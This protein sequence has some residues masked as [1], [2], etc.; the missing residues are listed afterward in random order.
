MPNDPL[1]PTLKKLEL[2]P[3]SSSNEVATLDR[4]ILSVTI[5]LTAT[6]A[7]VAIK[8][9]HMP[10][11]A[12]SRMTWR[13]PPVRS[14]SS[15]LTWDWGETRVR[16][17]G[18]CRA[19]ARGRVTTALVAAIV[20]VIP[21]LSIVR[22]MRGPRRTN[23]ATLDEEG[24]VDAGI[25]VVA[26][27]GFCNCA[28]TTGSGVSRTMS[29]LSSLSST[30]VD[31]YESVLAASS[32]SKLVVRGLLLR[33]LPTPSSLCSVNVR[34]MSSEESLA[35]RDEAAEG[36]SMTLPSVGEIEGKRAGDALE[37]ETDTVELSDAPRG[38]RVELIAAQWQVS[39]RCQ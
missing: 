14:S 35:R 33:S 12:I 29:S 26:G 22:D 37:G 1:L 25:I 18:M 3:Y 8:A 19:K 27:S 23:E 20:V 11:S 4:A 15:C 6:T 17:T 34:A 16:T 38:A 7:H 10:S 24:T 21:L 2:L 32:A 9:E 13:I 28:I 36:V 39:A 5:S 31:P 30:S